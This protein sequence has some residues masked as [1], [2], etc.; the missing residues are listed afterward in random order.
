MELTIRQTTAQEYPVTEVL[1][2]DAFW[3]V[4][5][6]GCDEHL[7]LHKIRNSS[8]YIRQLDLLAVHQEK[9]MGHIIST[10]AKVTGTSEHEVLCVGPVSVLPEFQNKGIGSQMMQASI[11]N[12]KCRASIPGI[13]ATAASILKTC[14]TMNGSL[15]ANNAPVVCF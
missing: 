2:R 11:K 4:Y 5:K 6:P 3:D 9:I 15:L 10:R 7:V 14:P 13:P 12:K 8:C 1:T